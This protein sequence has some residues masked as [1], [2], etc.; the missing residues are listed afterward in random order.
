[1]SDNFEPPNG[2]DSF[3]TVSSESW[4]S[5]LMGAFVGILIG[6]LLIPGAIWL[7]AWNEGR[8]V[9][10]ARALAEGSGARHRGVARPGQPGQPGP[11]R[12]PDGSAERS[13]NLIGPG[14]WRQR[15]GRGET[16][17][18]CRDVPMAADRKRRDP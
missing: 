14:L 11:S 4:L 12:A 2:G 5:R 9:D 1:M 13:G 3:T 16:H 8:A 15:A 7:I 10:T 17:P 6:L 18:P